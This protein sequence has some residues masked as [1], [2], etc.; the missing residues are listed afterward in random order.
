MGCKM[1]KG[2]NFDLANEVAVDELEL[3]LFAFGQGHGTSSV[4]F[5]YI[6]RHRTSCQKL[7][8]GTRGVFVWFY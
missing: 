7:N 4:E 2:S 6:K 5:F 1:C 3:K 8:V